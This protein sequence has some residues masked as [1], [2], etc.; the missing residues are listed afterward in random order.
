V[1]V[2]T[3]GRLRGGGAQGRRRG[4]RQTRR[5]GI[6]AWQIGVR[7]RSP[8]AARGARLFEG[9]E[10]EQADIDT[11]LGAKIGGGVVDDGA[12]LLEQLKEHDAV[13]E[14]TLRV[15]QVVRN[16]EVDASIDLVRHGGVVPNGRLRDVRVIGLLDEGTGDHGGDL[17]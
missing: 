16:D 1:L 7:A 11:R 9:R 4:T 10:L 5:G 17:D 8:G 14:P 6:D 13:L 12:A 15:L 3:T 2:V